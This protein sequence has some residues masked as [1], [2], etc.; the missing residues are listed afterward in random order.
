MVDYEMK[1]ENVRL[2]REDLFEGIKQ[3]LQ[4]IPVLVEQEERKVNV[5]FQDALISGVSV[6]DEGYCI[7]NASS[8]WADKTTYL[9][10]KAEDGSWFYY[11]ESIDE[12]IGEMQRLVMFEAQKGSRSVSHARKESELR[13]FVTED[14]FKT[15]YVKFMEQ[16]D[17]NVISKKSQGSK[18]PDGFSERNHFDGADFVQHFGQGAASKTPYMNWWVVSIYYLP[19]SGNIIMG[20]EEDRY[21]YLKKMSPLRKTQIGNKKT[22]IAVFYSATKDSVNYGELHKRFIEVSEEVMSLGLR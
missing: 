3:A 2:R 7:F 22:D 18:C 15:S 13:R 4:E 1:Q 6:E 17:K 11:L 12:C 8:E 19:D 20:I 21:P 9:C 14:L 10:D 16:A 5:M